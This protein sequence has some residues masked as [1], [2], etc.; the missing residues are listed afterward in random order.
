MT[1]PILKYPSSPFVFEVDASDCGTGAVFS[2]RY[3]TPGK[4]AF[5]LKNV[6]SFPV[7]FLLPTIRIYNVGNTIIL[8][9]KAMLEEWRHWLKVSHHPF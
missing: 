4:C 5:W 3:G 8:S 7:S 9:N 1:A 2:Q 6:L